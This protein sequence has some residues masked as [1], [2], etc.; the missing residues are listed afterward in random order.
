MLYVNSFDGL[1][2]KSGKKLVRFETFYLEIGDEE[3][4]VVVNPKENQLFRGDFSTGSE[5]MFPI[6][7]IT[8]WYPINF[9]QFWNYSTLEYSVEHYRPSK[10]YDKKAQFISITKLCFKMRWPHRSGDIVFY[11]FS[12]SSNYDYSELESKVSIIL[13]GVSLKF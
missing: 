10:S 8:S 9:S 7:L 2:S 12:R 1:K 11:N 13:L 6:V 4:D 5:H 3:L